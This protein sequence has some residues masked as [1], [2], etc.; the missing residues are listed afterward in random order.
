MFIDFEL[1]FPYNVAHLLHR[2]HGLA[3]CIKKQ[4]FS[5]LDV[6]GFHYDLNLH[7]SESYTEFYTDIN[8]N[9]ILFKD[10][11]KEI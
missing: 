6:L 3:G 1:S 10:F 11:V 5:Y 7:I 9:N 4:Q 2:A 8:N